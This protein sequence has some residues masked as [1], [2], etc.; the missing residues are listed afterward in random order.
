MKNKSSVMRNTA[1]VFILVFSS[2][3]LGGD[4]ETLHD[5]V[6]E[7][8]S[9]NYDF[10]ISFS[11]LE[12]IT[13]EITGPTLSIIGSAEETAKTITIA[14]PAQYD[15]GSIIWFYNGIRI[16]A[17]A[18]SGAFGETIT[19]SSSVYNRIG[20]HFLTVEV[21]KNGNYYSKTISFTVTL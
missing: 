7:L 19:L 4:I 13:P 9:D 1:L 18:V 3:V 11:Q 21:K 20:T 6:I 14:N 10:T 2:C 5:M 16:N 17:P 8:N 12:D 15:S